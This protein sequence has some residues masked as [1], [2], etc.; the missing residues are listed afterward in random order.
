M[1][2]TLASSSL[3][4][5]L[6]HFKNPTK[7]EHYLR[8]NVVMVMHVGTI[9]TM[10]PVVARITILGILDSNVINTPEIFEHLPLLL[11]LSLILYTGK[12]S[13]GS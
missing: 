11:T 4:C 9:K 8:L 6:L 7:Q 1:P 10:I 13:G 2:K 5:I 12:G 3:L